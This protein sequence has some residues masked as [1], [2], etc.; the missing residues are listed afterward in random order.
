MKVTEQLENGEYVTY[1]SVSEYLNMQFLKRYG[2]K[3]CCLVL[4]ILAV[5]VI[6]LIVFLFSEVSAFLSS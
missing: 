1:E 4:L 2:C 3:G 6:G 5:I